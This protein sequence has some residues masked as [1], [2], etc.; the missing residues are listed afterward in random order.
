MILNKSQKQAEARSK[1]SEA[2]FS[3]SRGRRPFLSLIHDYFLSYRN[4]RLKAVACAKV[5][6]NRG[7]TLARVLCL[8][9][10]SPMQTFNDIEGG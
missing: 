7:W 10:P 5:A 8:K 9:R 3:A 2:V 4:G 1:T 6:Q